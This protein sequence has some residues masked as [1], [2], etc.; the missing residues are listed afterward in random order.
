MRR[1]RCIGSSG[2]QNCGR[3]Q[4]GHLHRDGRTRAAKVS[5]TNT[6]TQGF[7]SVGS[8]LGFEVEDQ[9]VGRLFDQVVHVLVGGVGLTPR[10]GNFSASDIRHQ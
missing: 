9:G 1:F 3:V 2:S 7:E 5:H 6:G 10:V 8:C 4:F